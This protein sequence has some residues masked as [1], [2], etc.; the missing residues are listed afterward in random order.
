MTTQQEI[1]YPFSAG[2]VFISQILTY[3]IETTLVQGFRSAMPDVLH[4]KDAI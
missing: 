1:I 3:N 4:T 2:T